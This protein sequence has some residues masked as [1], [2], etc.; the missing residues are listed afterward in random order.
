[1]PISMAAFFV[2]GIVVGYDPLGPKDPKGRIPQ[3]PQLLRK[4]K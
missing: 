3:L 4:L 1:M 2:L